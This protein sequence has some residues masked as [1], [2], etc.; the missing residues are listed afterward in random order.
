M[1]D[2]ESGKWQNRKLDRLIM[3]PGSKYEFVKHLNGDFLDCRRENMVLTDSK[4]DA[5]QAHVDHPNFQ[6]SHTPDDSMGRW[7]RFI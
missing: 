3:K 1:K 2:S 4:A 7:D 5:G 6:P